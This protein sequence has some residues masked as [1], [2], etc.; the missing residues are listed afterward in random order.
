MKNEIIH[1]LVTPLCDRNCK[2]CCNK[3]YDLNDTPI[4][5][6]DELKNAH[7]LLLTGGEPFAYTNPSAIAKY[8]K[9]KYPNIKNVYVYGN[10]FEL[11]IYL[12]NRH[13]LDGIDGVSVSIK[14]TKD[15][16]YFCIICDN[17]HIT[18]LASNRLYVFGDLTPKHLGN[19][20]LIRREW[21]EKFVPA[22]DS[23]FRRM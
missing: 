2:H 10:A 17:K 7:T 4:I 18:K 6:D 14:N 12:I 20:Q 16:D 21:Q 19:F 9:S 15:K 8:Y 22:N 23:I 3:Q 5:T 1:L 11:G 13:S